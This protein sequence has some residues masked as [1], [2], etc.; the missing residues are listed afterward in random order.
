M[1]SVNECKNADFSVVAVDR[2]H[3]LP[4]CLIP[5]FIS[6]AAFQFKNIRA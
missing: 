4:V 2:H 5:L 6:T 3:S 1:I